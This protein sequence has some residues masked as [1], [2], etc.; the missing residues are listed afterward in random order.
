MIFSRAEFRHALARLKKGD[1]LRYHQG[2]LMA[3]RQGNMEVE[4]VAR[5]AW[6]AYREGRCLLTQRRITKHTTDLGPSMV[7]Y[8]AVKL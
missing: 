5:A 2:L 4:A 3:D 7:D 1:E 6:A 8:L